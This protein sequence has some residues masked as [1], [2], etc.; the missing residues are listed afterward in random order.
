MHPYVAQE[1]IRERHADLMREAA[2][3]ARVPVGGSSAPDARRRLAVWL[4]GL[5][6]RLDG[7]ATD[8]IVPA[9]TS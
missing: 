6:D 8:V 1:L 4:R 5:A 2:L 3:R 9:P 7:S